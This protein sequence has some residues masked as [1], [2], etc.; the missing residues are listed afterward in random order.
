MPPPPLPALKQTAAPTSQTLPQRDTY[1]RRTRAQKV[2]PAVALMERLSSP[3]QAQGGGGGGKAGGGEGGKP[4]ARAGGG[5]GG[6][7]AAGGAGAR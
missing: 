7:K 2:T 1:D 3:Q 5:S 4:A 6:G